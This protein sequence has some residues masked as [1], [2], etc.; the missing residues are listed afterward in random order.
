MCNNHRFGK[1]ASRRDILRYTLAGMGRRGPRALEQGPA[2]HGLRR[3]RH[4]EHPV[5][6]QH[7]RGQRQPEHGVPTTQQRYYDR[8]PTIA[9]PGGPA[10]GAHRRSQ[11]HHQVHAQPAHDPHPGHVERRRRGAG[12]P[13][14]LPRRQRLALRE[15]GHL[16]LGPAPGLGRPHGP[17]ER[18]DRALRR[19]ATRPPRWARC[20]VGIGRRRDFSGGSTNPL[21]L[22]RLRDFRFQSDGT[23][24]NNH[25]HR[26]N[27]IRQ[28]LQTPAHDRPDRRGPR[29]AR[30][31]PPAGG[32]GAGRAD[33]LHEHGRSTPTRG[34]PPR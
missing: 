1:N 22:G 32:P 34:W 18:L 9:D 19:P 30:L 7:V 4:A 8:R 20:R 21:L 3:R 15:R 28:V 12:D 24:A 11:P 31:G 25:T 2:G 33:R 13:G 17:G 23:Y 6:H 16:V 26:I 29:G 27:T 14:G 10:A 5:H